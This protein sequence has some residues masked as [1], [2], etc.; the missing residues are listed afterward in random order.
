MKLLR[1]LLPFLFSVALISFLNA[2]CPTPPVNG[3]VSGNS[4]NA[5]ISNG[6]DLFFD[7]NQGNFQVP[8]D[9]EPLRSTIFAAGLWMGAF[10]ES[11]NLRISAQ[12]YGRYSNRFDFTPGPLNPADGENLEDH[13]ERYNKI[14][15]VEK[16]DILSHLEDFQGDGVIENPIPSIFGWPGNNNEHF[17]YYNGFNLPFNE[18]KWAPFVDKNN[19]GIYEPQLGEYPHPD[20]VINN[21]IPEQITWTVF[22][23]NTERDGISSETIGVPLKMEIQ[24]TSW[25]FSC[26]GNHVLEHS[27]F[28]SYKIINRS[29][30]T[31]DSM[32]VGLFVDF[33]NGCYLDDFIGSA[34]EQD[35]FYVYNSDALDGESSANDCVGVETYGENPPAQSVAFLNRSLDKF[36]YFHGGGILP[37]PNA[38]HLPPETPAEFYN[39]LSGSWADGSPLTYGGDGRDPISESE[40]TDHAFPGNPMD[41]NGWSQITEG[42]ADGDFRTIGS[43]YIGIFEPGESIK[44]NL[45]HTYHGY[46]S[47]NNLESADQAYTEL[48]MMQQMYDMQFNSWC[49]DIVADVEEV[50]LQGVE[51]SPNPNDGIFRINSVNEEIDEIEVYDPLGRL[52]YF[53]EFENQKNIEMNLRNQPSGL[54]FL[55]INSNN[56]ST[57]IKVQVQ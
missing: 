3:T 27:L 50:Q 23:D 9:V 46:P 47:L 36:M 28:T 38:N 1:F 26:L 35:G 33:D 31:L 25:N 7:G 15:K 16:S 49:S 48:A 54:Y 6:G 14:W 55:K 32:Y 20:N 19:N 12:G 30:E 8:A 52:V 39:Y 18:H 24:L 21:L 34:P 45:A 29:Q 5:T 4:V 56:L 17:F 44:I 41:E 2:Q 51:I 42:F 13:C 11:E 10:D 37:P 22:N 53:R 43:S 40:A 57:S